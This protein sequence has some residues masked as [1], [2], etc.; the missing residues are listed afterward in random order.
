MIP[1]RF[2]PATWSPAERAEISAAVAPAKIDN[3]LTLNAV[4]H[5]LQ[6]L[7]MHRSGHALI[8]DE[9]AIAIKGLRAVRVQHMNSRGR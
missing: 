6:L 2:N 8:M 3:K 7:D 9:V 5:A 1:D 4:E